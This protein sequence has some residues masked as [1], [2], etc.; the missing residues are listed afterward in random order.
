MQTPSLNAIFFIA[1]C[2]ISTGA[3]AENI[4]KCGNSYSMTPCPGGVLVDTADQRTSEQ[5]AQ[6]DLASSRDAQTAADLEKRR[7]QQEAKAIA[8][9][10]PASKPATASAHKAKPSLLKSKRPKSPKAVASK[11]S[12]EKKKKKLPNKVAGNTDR[13]KL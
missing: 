12:P 11:A 9:I 13:N 5:K 3:K 10:Q 6:A 8:A 7:L 1:V 4:Y 2:A